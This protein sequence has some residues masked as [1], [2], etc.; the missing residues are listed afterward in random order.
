[1]HNVVPRMRRLAG[2]Q[3]VWRARF[4]AL[5]EAAILGALAKLSGGPNEHEAAAVDA[6]QELDLK[7]C[8]RALAR[9]PLPDLPSVDRSPPS[10]QVGVAFSRFQTR[11]LEDRFRRLHGTTISF[12]PCQT[13]A[14]AFVVARHVAM[15]QFVPEPFWRLTLKLALHPDD[16]AEEDGRALR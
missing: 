11:Y 7:V 8:S 2:Q 16:D 4:S 12:G 5:S 9:L 6:R 1:M 15:Q 14:L 13:P 3:Q 10:A